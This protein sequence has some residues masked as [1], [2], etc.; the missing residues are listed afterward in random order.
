MPQQKK[1]SRT[2]H[3]F[4][5]PYK[6]SIMLLSIVVGL[7]I[8]MVSYMMWSQASTLPEE[9]KALNRRV[10]ALFPFGGPYEQCED[11]VCPDISGKKECMHA[12]ADDIMKCCQGVCHS[13]CAH[14]P[15]PALEEC[16]TAC[17][18]LF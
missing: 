12:K 17:A 18:P 6:L 7:L 14:L 13:K 3:L 11:M 8:A 1:M 16:L 9:M 15:E 10:L 4:K 2:S 5:T